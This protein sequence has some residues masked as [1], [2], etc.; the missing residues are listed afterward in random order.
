MKISNLI[1]VTFIFL[2]LSFTGF[3]TKDNKGFRMEFIDVGQGD[4]IYISTPKGNKILVDGGDNYSVD[5]EIA[6]L[7]P[8]YSCSLDAVILT[9]PHYDHLNGLNRIIN[10]CRISNVMFND[11]D[12]TSRGFSDFKAIT[13]NMNVRNLY[14]GDEFEIDNVKFKVLWPT[15][16]FTQSRFDDVNDTS[17]VLF[18]DYGDFEAVLLGD[19]G[20]EVLGKLDLSS[21]LPLVD[22]DFDVIKVSHHGSKYALNKSFYLGLKPKNC[23]I[24]VGKDNK[25]GHPDKNVLDFLQ[26]I[27]CAILRTD[28]KGNIVLNVL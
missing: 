24:S 21:I 27:N 11:V 18:V 26:S 28:L 10:R 1:M 6:N 16:E 8:F 14:E 20:E 19:A 25:F 5:F 17:I 3:F 15:K 7:I 9:H 22:G 4:S 12:F 2:T 13:R 23:V